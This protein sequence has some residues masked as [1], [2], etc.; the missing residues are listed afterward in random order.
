MEPNVEQEIVTK[1]EEKGISLT[2]YIVSKIL[3]EGQKK[4]LSERLEYILAHSED[5]VINALKD[6]MSTTAEV[7]ED[8]LKLYEVCNT[9]KTIRQNGTKSPELLPS[10]EKKSKEKYIRIKSAYPHKRRFAHDI[11]PKDVVKEKVKK[12]YRN[13]KLYWGEYIEMKKFLHDYKRLKEIK[14]HLGVDNG[15]IQAYLSMLDSEGKLE[16]IEDYA[17]ARDGVRMK[18]PFYKIKTVAGDGL[19]EYKSEIGEL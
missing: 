14:E 6:L 7:N 11:V 17:T 19:K 3:T 2:K 9:L 10:K 12:S 18:V 5:I 16:R 8:Y 15:L 4:N 13:R 1:K